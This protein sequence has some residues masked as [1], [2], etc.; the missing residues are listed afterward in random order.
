MGTRMAAWAGLSALAVWL[1]PRAAFCGEAP[2]W[3]H[4]LAA[5]PLP[6]HDANAPAILLYSETALAV[7]PRD[8]KLRRTERR[9][10]KILRPEGE[11]RGK[12]TL[13]MNGQTEVIELRAWCIPASGKD[14]EVGK[15]DAVEAAWS[16]VP[17][18]LLAS[19]TRGMFL[20]IPAAVP[21]SV[22]GYESLEEQTPYVLADTWTFQDTI[23][24]RE[25][26]YN[27][28]LPEGW[29]YKAAWVNH[30]DTT[31]V[32]AGK[33]R[34]QWQ[35][36]DVVSARV[37][38]HMSS[39]GGVLGKMFITLIPPSGRGQALQSW[40]DFGAWY[41]NLAQ[42][43]RDASP[44]LKRKVLELTSAE[45]TQL[46]KMRS[47]A[48]FVQNDIRYVAI[49]LGI[50]GYQPHTAAEVF[51]HR[52]GDC[53][54]KATLLS[55]MLAEIGVKSYYVIINAMRGTV[56]AETPPNASSF[57]HAILAVELPAGID[58]PSLEAT[59]TYSRVG[60]VLFFDPT[61]WLTPFGSL[62][63]ALQ[64]NHAL[65]V[66]SDGGELVELPQLPA[67]AN[68]IARTA[69]LTLDGQGTLRGDVREVRMGNRAARQRWELR[70][71][72][73]DT[74]QIKP[75]E[76]LLSASLPEGRVIKA[77]VLNL[78]APEKPFEWQYSIE[79]DHYARASGDLVLVRPRVIGS[80]AE[81]FLETP[82]KREHD[83]EFDEPERDV[84]TVE[85]TLP[86]GYVVDQLPAPVDADTGFASYHS[87]TDVVGRTLRYVR[88]FEISKLS[89]PAGRADELKALYRLIGTDERNSVVFERPAP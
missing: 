14:Y 50:G 74:D 33:D 27:L 32:S 69:I 38:P 42:G 73:A 25:T 7:G 41:T 48:S 46:G 71:A 43:R 8:G 59:A 1:L 80:K 62:R 76:A 5:A 29:S 70:T 65:L 77:S 44:E 15:H 72:K 83:I 64:A 61:D 57:N 36:G 78:H 19:D 56:T 21:G 34:W 54:D 39:L 40:N 82:E 12:V 87:K 11:A 22:V 2:K 31:P 30:A 84:D 63:G 67:S 37:E 66:E 51:S 68:G 79:A 17:N 85:I 18:G 24:V 20:Q 6:A 75:I 16:D 35:L 55:A 26:H 13:V 89:I 47:L 9:V 88:Q 58:D 53:K 60:R 10:Y 4:A 28:T 86:P 52:Y 81:K 49:E 45:S 23:P 3:M